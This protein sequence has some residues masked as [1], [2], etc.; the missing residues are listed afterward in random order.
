MDPVLH[1]SIEDIRRPFMGMQNDHIRRYDRGS[2]LPQAV[3][4]A[5]SQPVGSGRDPGIK[6][7]FGR[8]FSGLGSGVG[9]TPQPN[10]TSTPSR[11][12]PLDE[13]KPADKPSRRD[14][15]HASPRG[16][17]RTKRPPGDDPRS[18]MQRGDTKLTSAALSKV[19][20]RNRYIQPPVP[21]HHHHHPAPP[22]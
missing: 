17:R 1:Q 18:N 20:K 21:P 13:R 15:N 10:G 22:Q 4:G 7:E 3:Q 8:M 19:P 6:S 16:G 2:P 11:R 9:S 12:S 14:A 5:Q